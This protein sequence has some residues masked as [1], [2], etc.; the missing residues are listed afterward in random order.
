MADNLA[1]I[2]AGYGVMMAI[3]PLLQVRR[4]V[5]R[6]SSADVSLSYIGL[7]LPGWLVWI[8]YGV[9]IANVPLILANG[10]AFIV[11]VLTFAVGFRY[12]YA[13]S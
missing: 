8:A 5:D 3:A 4:M 6:R 1:L 10:L 12:R 11:G 2:A 13:P 7:L 9:S